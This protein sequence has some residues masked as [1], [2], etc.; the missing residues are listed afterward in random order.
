[1][2][3]EEE[4]KMKIL[5]VRKNGI[6]LSLSLEEAEQY[7]EQLKKIFER[8]SKEIVYF[9]YFSCSSPHTWPVN[10]F[11]Q[12]SWSSDPNVTVT[13]SQTEDSLKLN[14]SINEDSNTSPKSSEL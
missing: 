1:M 14:N 5:L 7:Y 3:E 11:P 10:L 6:D 13:S 2:R 9:P 4:E 12:S 8:E